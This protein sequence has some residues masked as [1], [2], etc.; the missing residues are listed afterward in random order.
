MPEKQLT[1]EFIEKPQSS[2][3]SKRLFCE[4]LAHL[5]AGLL[6]V[7]ERGEP[8]GRFGDE[9]STLVAEVDILDERVYRSALIGGGTAVGEAFVDQ[10]WT[11]PDVTRVVR[12]FAKNLHM[13]D[14]WEGRFSWLVTPISRI[15]EFSRRNT[16]KQSKR[17]I[18]AHYDLGNDLYTRF[19]DQRMQ[20]SA[21]LFQRPQDS[22]EVAQCNKLERIC[23]EL[24][25]GPEDHLLE[26]GCGWGGLALFAAANY[27]CKVTATTISDA[28]FSYAQ[29]QIAAAGLTDRVELINRDYR[30]LEGTY[31]KIVSVEMIEAVGKQFLP[32]F[33]QRL[34][35]LLKPEGKLL[36]QA[37]TISDQRFKRYANRSDFIR[38]HIFPGGFLPSLSILVQQLAQQSE[39]VVRDVHDMGFDYAQTL[40]C[41]RQ[42][43][44]SNKAELQE[45]GYDDRF[46]RLWL[47]YLGYCEGGFLERHISA[48][49]V[50]ASK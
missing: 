47:Y 2:T 28:Q 43:L 36:L 17:N 25:L 45:F 41:W 40:N 39:L 8:M 3:L 26:I 32:R 9:N 44:L 34:G 19:L 23:E 4:L 13:L 7:K 22:L 38:K 46:M 21:A 49:Q 20:Y 48:V 35:A 50:V 18:L 42:R 14:K 24:D 29:Q 6:I 37:I 11:T 15:G 31:D 10:W 33:F 16:L 12:L 30:L 27:G 1:A 5:R